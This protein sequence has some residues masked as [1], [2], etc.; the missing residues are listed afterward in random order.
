MMLESSGLCIH[1]CSNWS[2]ALTLC[3]SSSPT[4]GLTFSLWEFNNVHHVSPPSLHYKL[5]VLLQSSCLLVTGPHKHHEPAYQSRTYQW[6]SGWG[7]LKFESSVD[8]MIWGK[9]QAVGWLVAKISDGATIYDRCCWYWGCG[10]AQ[11]LWMC[12]PKKHQL[13]PLHPPK[14]AQCIH[15][16][17][18]CRCIGI[19]W[20]QTQETH[21]PSPNI[22][23]LPHTSILLHPSGHNYI[24]HAM[25]ASQP[26]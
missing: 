7:H 21:L 11:A 24:S 23:P 6:V 20:Q 18:S 16:E 22:W 25:I 19:N 9:K 14:D 3:S 12:Q 26:E 10:V 13:E 2:S 17:H 8:S 4:R 1:Y 5:L 15:C